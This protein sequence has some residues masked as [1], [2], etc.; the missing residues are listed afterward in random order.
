MKK[1]M[2][3]TKHDMALNWFSPSNIK[4]VEKHLFDILS[5]S[6]TNFMA[7][8][9]TLLQ[10][11]SLC[12]ELVEIHEELDSFY[13]SGDMRETIA[14]SLLSNLRSDVHNKLTIQLNAAGIIV[15]TLSTKQDMFPIRGE[16]HPWLHRCCITSDKSLNMHQKQRI[17]QMFKTYANMWDVYK[18]ME[19]DYIQK[20]IDS[21]Y[22]SKVLDEW[23]YEK[24]ILGTNDIKNAQRLMEDGKNSFRIHTEY[25]GNT[26]SGER[27]FSNIESSTSDTLRVIHEEIVFSYRHQY[28]FRI[29]FPVVLL[30]KKGKRRRALTINFSI[31]DL[32]IQLKEPGLAHYRGHTQSYRILRREARITSLSPWGWCC[33]EV[34]LGKPSAA[35]FFSFAFVGTNPT[36]QRI[37]A[38]K[39]FCEHAHRI[40]PRFPIPELEGLVQDLG[41]DKVPLQFK[42]EKTPQAKYP[43]HVAFSHDFLRALCLTTDA[44]LLN[45]TL[46]EFS[47][48]SFLD[49]VTMEDI[50]E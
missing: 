2:D 10:S 5:E 36:L 47:P 46:P 13:I 9:T 30:L 3:V 18:L 49:S 21:K 32:S 45:E 34:A 43:R 8:E 4:Q 26:I 20:F 25:D 35:V 40:F 22:I 15:K 39:Q 11:M 24:Y 16:K 33:K 42:N 12:K 37:Q 44:M 28:N 38:L 14:S 7:F 1:T 29:D 27:V 50:L 31:F 19:T 41:T 48:P 17:F 23:T 6:I